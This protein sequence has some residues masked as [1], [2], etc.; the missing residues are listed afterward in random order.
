MDFNDLTKLLTILN[1]NY[2][3]TNEKADT[4]NGILW[5]KQDPTI[6]YLLSIRTHF[7]YLSIKGWK[8]NCSKMMCHSSVNYGMGCYKIWD[9]YIN[10]SKK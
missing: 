3:R 9:D 5:K 10:I 1:A 6:C 2:V 7:K 8:V 4:S